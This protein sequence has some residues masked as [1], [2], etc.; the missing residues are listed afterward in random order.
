MQV[1]N[2]MAGD[3]TESSQK[4][5]DLQETIVPSPYTQDADKLFKQIEVS[6]TDSNIDIAKG[7]AYSG[8]IIS[9]GDDT[10]RHL[11]DTNRTE[12]TL[13][14]HPVSLAKK[15]IVQKDIVGDYVGESTTLEK[16]SLCVYGA[17]TIQSTTL[18]K[19]LPSLYDCSANTIKSNILQN[20]SLDL[21][22]YS[23]NTVL[24]T[25][26]QK[27]SPGLG[28]YGTNTIQSTTL[29]KDSLVPHGYGASLGESIKFQK[30]SLNLSKDVVVGGDLQMEIQKSDVSV[31]KMD[32]SSTDPQA[33]TENKDPSTTEGYYGRSVSVQM[34]SSLASQ[35]S[36]RG[37]I[38]HSSTGQKPTSDVQL[39]RECSEHLVSDAAN[40]SD[41]AQSTIT[42]TVKG[43][44]LPNSWRSQES[45]KRPHSTSL[46]KSR[47][48]EEDTRWVAALWSGAQSCGSCGHKWHSCC[49]NKNSKKQF[50]GSQEQLH[51]ASSLP[52]S[53]S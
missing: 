15:G 5:E 48:Y 13:I 47:S 8:M 50:S 2:A 36:L 17:N 28:D 46:D 22:D 35:S 37:N 52:V 34:C 20:E 6:A 9:T 3:S 49:Q 27:D 16:D 4:T 32:S 10:K 51:L 14:E 23:A 18:K 24:N 40:I 33:G 39:K 7:P 12:Q 31:F 26:L 43:H 1:L 44:T 53:H 38:I 19:D 29:Q 30:I 45:S 25:S 42:P 41:N 11:Q 21:H